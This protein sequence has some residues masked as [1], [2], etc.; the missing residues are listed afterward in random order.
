[1]ESVTRSIQEQLERTVMNTSINGVCL[2][3]G[4]SA[5]ELQRLTGDINTSTAPNRTINTRMSMIAKIKFPKFHGDD[6]TGWVYRC[7]QFFKVDDIV[8]D[9]KVKLALMHLYD[10]ALAWHQQFTRNHGENMNWE[11]EVLETQA[12]SFFLGGLDKEIEMIVRMFK[13]QSLVDAYCLSKLQEANNSVSRKINKS[14]MPTPKPVYN[15]FV[16]NPGS[17]VQSVNYNPTKAKHV[18]NNASYTKQLTK[19][20]LDEKRAK[21]Q[22][23]NCDQRYIPSHKCSGELFSLEILEDNGVIDAENETHCD[24]G[25][26]GYGES[27]EENRLDELNDCNNEADRAIQPQ[28]SLN[29]NTPKNMSQRKYVRKRYFIIQ[30]HKIQENDL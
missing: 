15:N 17:Q 14:S 10:K 12:V 6:P 27:A 2:R 8:E 21:N 3:Q 18:Y 7:N 29:C 11:V 24:E 26:F 22:C 25:V 4:A 9:V 16:R 28:I 19:K 20:E 13:P 23:F 30:Q 5:L 1:M